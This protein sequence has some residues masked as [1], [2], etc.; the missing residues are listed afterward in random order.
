[1]RNFLCRKARVFHRVHEMDKAKEAYEQAK[2]IAEE[3]DKDENSELRKFILEVESD[4]IATSESQSMVSDDTPMVRERS[5][6]EL[7]HLKMQARM[8][9]EK[10]SLD[11]DESSFDEALL[12]YNQALDLYMSLNDCEGVIETH[13]ERGTVYQS[14]GDYN[15]A[16]R[17][18]TQARLLSEEN[19]LE[20]FS[21]DALIRLGSL[22]Y[23]RAN[24]QSALGNFQHAQRI[25]QD[26][27]DILKM[28]R[29]W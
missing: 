17:D 26:N 19:T 27:E 13:L 28:S 20:L 14:K 12:S 10:G 25:A 23:L 29:F 2:S 21:C 3:I 9:L 11:N 22:D 16:E 24:Y 5:E 8:L 18:F 7:Q 6:D 1:M 15:L 4:F